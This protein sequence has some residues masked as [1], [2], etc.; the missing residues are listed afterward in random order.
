MLTLPEPTGPDHDNWKKGTNTAGGSMRTLRIAVPVGMAI[1][2][3]E[4]ADI[5]AFADKSVVECCLADL[6]HPT[7]Q[8]PFSEAR[9]AGAGIEGRE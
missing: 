2:I 4:C 3:L 5:E 7:Q 6:R 9:P 1:N 8:V